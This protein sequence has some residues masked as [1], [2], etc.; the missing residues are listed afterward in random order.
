MKPLTSSEIVKYANR[1]GAKKIAVENFLSTLGNAGSKYG[2]LI[3]LN[4]D[5]TLYK[6]NYATI[7]AIEAGISKAYKKD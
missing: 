5:A 7:R 1:R 6:W 3:N 4:L 2:E